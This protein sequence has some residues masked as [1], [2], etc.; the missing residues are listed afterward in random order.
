MKKQ[1][2]VAVSLLPILLIGGTLVTVAVLKN[3]DAV[4]VKSAESSKEVLASAVFR[5]DTYGV[6]VSYPVD[7]EVVPLTEQDKKDKF[8]LKF[9][10]PKSPE[11]VFNV[12]AETGLRLPSQLAKI[13]VIDLVLNG[14]LSSLPLRYP[15][16]KLL[17]QNKLYLNNKEAEVVEFTYIGPAKELVRQKLVLV[18][19]DSDS[20]LYFTMQSKDS[21][22][23]SLMSSVFDHV[24]NDV[25]FL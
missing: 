13:D 22:F 4:K 5:D 24:L 20:A 10:H 16:Y 6:S 12:R 23:D 19:K 1:H 9:Q 17:G 2:I 7:A 11:Y 8:I 25:K 15:N 18:A 14:A 21:D 3:N